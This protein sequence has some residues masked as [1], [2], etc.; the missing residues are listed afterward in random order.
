MRLRELLPLGLN[1]MSQL[2]PTISAMMADPNEN[3][4]QYKS[5]IHKIKFGRFSST[6]IGNGITLY[7]SDSE[8]IGLDANNDRI[9]YRMEYSNYTNPLLGNY[10][11]QQWVWAD[12]NY[13]LNLPSRVFFDLVDNYHTVVCDERQTEPGKNF[14]IRQMHIAFSNGLNVYF[15]N[16]KT[17]MLIQLSDSG[18]IQK[19]NKIYQIWTSHSSSKDRV[20]VISS[21]KLQVTE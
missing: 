19:F 21:E 5:L 9:V 6:P 11:V 16:F 8:Y 17:N 15:I 1:E 12:S 14:W 13:N 3:E 2:M 18:D 7:D 20:F 10:V 4:Q